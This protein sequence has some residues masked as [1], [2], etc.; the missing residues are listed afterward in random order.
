[1]NNTE[2]NRENLADFLA[3][4]LEKNNLKTELV[5]KEIG[6]SSSTLQRIIGKLTYPTNEMLKQ[7]GIMLSIG[8]DKFKKLTEAEKEKI[9]EQIGAIGGGILGFGGIASAISASGVAGLSAA[10]IT[11]GLASIGALI[12]GG[13]I[14]GVVISAAI[15]IAIGAIGYKVVKGIKSM[16]NDNKLSTDKFD[17]FWEIIK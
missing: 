13:M 2:L 6:C 9:T 5:A 10:G 16:I 11:S 14:A 1:M 3:I 17:P 7:C 4:F 12:G 15:P 8:F